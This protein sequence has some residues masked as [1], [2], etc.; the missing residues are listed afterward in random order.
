MAA[1]A[2]LIPSRREKF[3]TEHP[4][5][6]QYAD[7]KELLDERRDRRRQRLPAELSAR[8]DHDRGAEGRQA[9]HVRKAAGDE[10]E[11]GE[12][13]RGGR[14]EGE[15]DRDVLGPAALRRG[16]AGGQAGDRQGLRRRCL[17]R[18]RIVDAHARHPDGH[19]L[20]HRQVQ[21]RRRGADRHRRPPARPRVVSCS[22]SPGR[23]APTASR[24]RASRT[25]WKASRSTSTTPPS[26]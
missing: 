13:D 6:K 23:S 17:S 11:G 21:G 9:R 12:A 2:D 25:R 3:L 16:G 15:E 4:G 20:V 14:G 1:I 18:P 7:A 8:A 5:A 24:T 22:A 19:R 26:R 10:R